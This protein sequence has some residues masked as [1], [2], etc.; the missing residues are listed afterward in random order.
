[1]M[2][3]QQHHHALPYAGLFS[4]MD[5]H[6]M[7]MAAAAARKKIALENPKMHNSEI[8]KQLGARWKLL[9]ESEK[10]PFID[11]A[12]R[13]R[14]MHMKDHPDYKYR[15]RRK[16]KA[17]VSVLP[18]GPGGKGP[19]HGLAAAAGFPGF[20]LP[21]FAHPQHPLEYPG[22]PGYFG[23]AFDAVNIQKL[24][25]AQQQSQQQSQYGHHQQSQQQ[26][27]QQQQL[28]HHAHSQQQQQYQSYGRGDASGTTAADVA[29]NNAAANAVVTSI[30]SLYGPSAASAKMS[31]YGAAAP[32]SLGS[33]LAHHQSM[34]AGSSLMFNATAAALHHQQAAVAGSSSPGSS[35]GSTPVSASSPGTHPNGLELVDQLR[36]PVPTII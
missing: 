9:S 8:S 12:K 10:A 35:P 25:S 27:Q 1:M 20:S 4:G 29:N 13:L 32:P 33:L 15:P 22:L 7:D 23:S 5:F 30:Y 36:R 24:V 28:A 16:P 31:P 17:P 19:A 3:S 11:E 14:A 34:S 6:R 2:A 26:A 18:N 21:Y